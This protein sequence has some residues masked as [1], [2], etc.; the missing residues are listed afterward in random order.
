MTFTS[1]AH[2]NVG[3]DTSEGP[4]SFIATTIASQSNTTPLPLQSKK[5][6]HVVPHVAPMSPPL[7]SFD[8]IYNDEVS[9]KKIN[10]GLGVI[11]DKSSGA[12]SD[13][14]LLWKNFDNDVPAYPEISSHAAVRN[15][16][17]ELV[18]LTIPLSPIIP[19]GDVQHNH[20]VHLPQA[21][22]LSVQEDTPQNKPRATKIPKCKQKKSKGAPPASG[23]GLAKGKSTPVRTKR[24][25]LA[26]SMSRRT[27]LESDNGKLQDRVTELEAHVKN[28]LK[29]LLKQSNLKAV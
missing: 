4:F 25:T 14:P 12:A 19:E 2:S 27:R 28:L 16:Y 1:V 8:D 22:S 15:K 7:T 26:E 17:N 24:R 10:H 5:E 9:L 11:A 23:P 3:N 20:H 21:L 29:D 13:L 6:N 18:P